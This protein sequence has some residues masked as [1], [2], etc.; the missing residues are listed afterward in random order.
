[1][2]VRGLALIL[3]APTGDA[4]LRWDAPDGCPDHAAAVAEITA[5]AGDHAAA[6]LQADVHVVREGPDAYVVRV[7]LR[8]EVVGHRELRAGSCAEALTATAVVIAIA[9]SPP[10]DATASPAVP[11]VPDTPDAATTDATDPTI[12][13]PAGTTTSATTTTTSAVPREIPSTPAPRRRRP[14]LALAARGGLDVGTVPGVAPLLT[15][16]IG[17]VGAR[18]HAAVG[19]VHRFAA[20]V[21]APESTDLGGRFRVTAA[22]LVAGPRFRW[23]AFELPLRVGVELG[24]LAAVGTGALTPHPVRRLWTAALLGV[25]GAWAPHRRVALQL[26]VDAI[27]P[28][29]RPRFVLGDTIDLATVGRAAVRAWLGV[30][31]RFSFDERPA[32]GKGIRGR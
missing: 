1:M 21:D 20:D 2:C 16:T 25:A 23:G 17:A 18:W 4:G 12:I 9:V 27:V 15:A 13:D 24:A 10:V 29:W 11:S 28:L 6:A 22:H 19:A 8:G 3:L 32:P 26:G 14:A 30:E 5:R 31:L 7:E